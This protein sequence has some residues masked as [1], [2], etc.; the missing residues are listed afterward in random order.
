MITKDVHNPDLDQAASKTF[1][2]LLLAC[3]KNIAIAVLICF[4]ISLYHMFHLF[5]LEQRGKNS[6]KDQ[7]DE[8]M[9]QKVSNPGK[10]TKISMENEKLGVEKMEV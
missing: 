9:E 7:P 10:T 6:K 2:E 4:V 5:V 1:I 3:N 8:P